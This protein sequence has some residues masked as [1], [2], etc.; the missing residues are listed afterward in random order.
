M[1]DINKD[2]LIVELFAFNKKDDAQYKDAVDQVRSLASRPTAD[3]RYEIAQIIRYAVDANLNQKLDYLDII[4]D[5]IRTE[6]GAKAEFEMEIDNLKAF[7]QAK[8]STTERSKVGKK[9]ATLSTQEVSVRPYVNFHELATGKVDVGQLITKASEKMEIA[10]TK[11]V[12]TVLYAGFSGLA[13]PN[14]AS[15]AGVVKNTFDPILTS[16][17][18]VAKPV[19]L[20]DAAVLSKLTALTGFNNVVAESLALEHNQN[21]FIGTYLGGNVVKLNNPFE[22]N[23]LT[24]T[25]LRQDLIYVIPAGSNSLRP[26]KIHLEGDVQSMEATNIDDKSYEVRLDKYVGV[27]LIGDTKFLGIYEDTTL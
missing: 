9:F 10:I 15:G 8:A 11:K 21:G 24:N 14:F 7:F 23:S 17:S 26:L 27:G 2:S 13:S 20:G 25:M 19:I 12:Q 5:V 22:V 16:M 3:N 4:A 6:Y 18:R 1:A